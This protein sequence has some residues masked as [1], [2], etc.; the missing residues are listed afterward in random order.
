MRLETARISIAL[1]IH[2]LDPTGGASRD[3]EIAPT[4]KDAISDS[5]KYRT[6]L[7]SR[8]SGLVNAFLLC[9]EFEFSGKNSVSWM[10]FPR[11]YFF[12]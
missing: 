3:Q 8:Q 1:V 6:C 10:R 9:K 4:T 5:A 2:S 12:T 7:N 11:Y